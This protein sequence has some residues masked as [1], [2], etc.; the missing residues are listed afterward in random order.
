MGKVRRLRVWMGERLFSSLLHSAS[1]PPSPFGLLVGS[2]TYLMPNSSRA[3]CNQCKNGLVQTSLAPPIAHVVD[4]ARRG[5]RSDSR[6]S[7]AY[8]SPVAGLF[9][10]ERLERA[11]Q[12]TSTSLFILG[13]EMQMVDRGVCQESILT[14]DEASTAS[15]VDREYVLLE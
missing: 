5:S 3:V 8:L 11:A 13:W 10:G 7:A 15:A 6:G 2:P 9:V 12:R 4:G 1:S 14:V